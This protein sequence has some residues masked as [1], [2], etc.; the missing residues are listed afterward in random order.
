VLRYRLA[1]AAILIPVVGVVFAAGRPWLDA[2]LVIVAL[3]AAFEAAS[4][5]R[6]AGHALVPPVAVAIAVGATV[7]AGLAVDPWLAASVP[8][9]GVVVAGV[10][11]FRYGDPREGLEAWAFTSFAGA[12]GGLVAFMIHLLAA[13]PAV[14]SGA[15]LAP[16]G[17][18]RAWLLVLVLG[19]WTYD[20]CAYVAGRL[21]GRRRFLEHLSPSKTYAGL[22]GGLLGTI[23][24][25]AVL[26]LALG[27]SPLEA[28]ALGPVIALAA[29]A[30]DLAESMLKRAA[31]VKDSG[32]LFPGHGGMLDR[33][34]SFLFAAPAVALYAAV[35]AS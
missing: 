13:G 1:T 25:A 14:A 31:G 11:A 20:S 5:L 29:Q 17:G 34:D 4:L 15:V 33:I 18:G 32:T 7:A 30:G 9:V 28:A 6:R 3:V 35:I 24:V 10:A 8:A 22:V 2:L 27:R 16:L 19:V 21:F 26:L 12:Y 23:A